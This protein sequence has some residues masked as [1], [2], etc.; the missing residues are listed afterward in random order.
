M[1]FMVTG[2]AGFIGSHTVDALLASG[3][4]VR[5]LDNFSSGKRE[6]LPTHPMLDII[7]GDI[8]DL[9][10]VREAVAGV[11]A[12][13]HLAAQVSVAASVDNPINSASHNISGFLNV[14]EA[15]RQAKTKRFV[16]ASSAAV[17]GQPLVLPLDET[18]TVAPLSPYGL[19]KSIN[20]QYA[21]LYCQLYGLSTL[22]LRYF[23]VY[24]PRQDP[25]SPYSGVI[26]IFCDRLRAAQSLCIFGDGGQTRDFIHVGDVAAANAAA[27]D[28]LAKGVCNIATG[29][30]CTLIELAQSLGVAAGR[31]PEIVF[32]NERT[33]DI[34]H[35]SAHNHRLREELGVTRFMPLTEGL[36]QLWDSGL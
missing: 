17:Y 9:D 4:K 32:A 22:G 34:R 24:G 36:R 1:N 29:Q 20:D 23:N 14:L 2:G 16:Y 15:C 27:L 25:R 10:T 5:V 33:G 8:R 26:S 19:E 21:A 31:A 3:A 18:A 6:N 13:L 11:D 30:T 35:S 28:G 12:V 7:T